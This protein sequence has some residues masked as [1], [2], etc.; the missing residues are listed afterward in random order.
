VPAG[1][2]AAALDRHPIVASLPRAQREIVGLIC[3][4]KSN[5]EIAQFRNVREQTVKNMLTQ[6]I[7][8]AFGVASRAALVSS[9]LRALHASPDPPPHSPLDKRCS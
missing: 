4:G 8:P 7:F 9:C 5:K 6:S 2:E 3:M 1:T